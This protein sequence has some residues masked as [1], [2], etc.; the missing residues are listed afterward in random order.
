VIMRG[1]QQMLCHIVAT[2][3]SRHGIPGLPTPP[4]H[5]HTH[6][7][8]W[9]RDILTLFM[10]DLLKQQAYGKQCASVAFHAHHITLSHLKPM[11]SK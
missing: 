10:L 9:T 7:S 8:V 1:G 4:P 11:R 3:G 2:S 5:A 6:H